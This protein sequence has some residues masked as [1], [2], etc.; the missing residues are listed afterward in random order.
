MNN[1]KLII[2]LCVVFLVALPVAA[3]ALTN[4]LTKDNSSYYSDMTNNLTK[5]TFNSSEKGTT[6]EKYSRIMPEKIVVYR[7]D[8]NKVEEMDFEEYIKGVVAKQL[9]DESNLEALK[10]QAVA[11]RT[12]ALSQMKAFGGE[13]CKGH[14]DV[15][16]HDICTGT[17][18]L[19]WASEEAMAKQWKVK[20]PEVY[21]GKVA[22]AVNMTKGV[23]LTYNG[24][25][26]YNIKDET[27]VFTST[28]TGTFRNSST[29]LPGADDLGKRGYSYEDIL[30]YYYPE[31][32]I[33]K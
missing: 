25:I 1:R 32:K 18:C 28:S 31:D 10:A 8:I 15:E 33:S 22:E 14:K 11:A 12:F 17:H 6:K 13:G 2:V 21:W 4:V 19:T 23:I 7:M 29:L 5:F 9:T 16:Y 30:K 24:G 3:P 27:T 20:E 26:P